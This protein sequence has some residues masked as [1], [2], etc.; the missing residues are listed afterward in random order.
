MS[1]HD[2]TRTHG[3]SHADDT[4]PARTTNP[5]ADADPAGA[6][7]SASDPTGGCAD[8]GGLRDSITADDLRA[9]PAAGETCGFPAVPIWTGWTS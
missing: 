5:T 2:P 3:A 9:A 1:G 4:A 8:S 7:R 6:T